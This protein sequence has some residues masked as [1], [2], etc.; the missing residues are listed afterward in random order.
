MVVP[1]VRGVRRQARQ[2]RTTTSG[3][4]AFLSPPR[5]GSLC[6]ARRE[7]LRTRI[8]LFHISEAAGI[9]RFYTRPSEYT[10]G[11]V[12][13][14][15]DA[16]HVRNYLLP[17]D[18]PRVTFYAGPDTTRKR[19]GSVPRRQSS[20][21]RRGVAAP[22]CGD[23]FHAAIFDDS[24]ADRCAEVSGRRP[25]RGFEPLPLHRHKLSLDIGYATGGGRSVLCDLPVLRRTRRTLC[26]TG[27]GGKLHSRL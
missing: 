26:G 12:V 21:C 24:D 10:S 19:R 7:I 13:S 16:E 18:C 5:P 1:P 25:R 23:R 14:A 11:P 4:A 3:R 20:S 2:Y 17:R 8:M 6:E 15:I 9:D 22:R 27:C